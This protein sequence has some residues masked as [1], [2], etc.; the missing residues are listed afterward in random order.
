MERGIKDKIM[1]HLEENNLLTDSQHGFRRNRSCLTNL[2]QYLNNVK[3]A[4]DE[5]LPVDIKYD[6]LPHQRLLLKLEAHGIKGKVLQWIADW[7]KGRRQRVRVGNSMSKWISVISSV[8]QGSVLGPI[9]FLIYI[10][11]VTEY[12]VSACSPTTQR[13]S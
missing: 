10:N 13:Q 5:G 1:E 11:D 3:G 9:L 7:L 6:K 12:L 8:A 2:L 4:L